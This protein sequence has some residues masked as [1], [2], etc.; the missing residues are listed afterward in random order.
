MVLRQF[1]CISKYMQTQNLSGSFAVFK[2]KPYLCTCMRNFKAIIICAAALALAGC[3][4]SKWA[5]ESRWFGGDRVVNEGYADVFYFVSTNVLEEKDDNGKDT[6]IAKLTDEEKNALNGEMGFIRNMFGDSLNFF[7]PYYSQ[8]TMNALSLPEKDYHK[9]RSVALKD[10]ESAFRYYLRHKNNG[11][12]YILIGFSQGAMHLVDILKNVSKKDYERM[13]T[14]YSMGYRLSAD[15]LKHR[16]VKA[17]EGADDRGTIVSF[18]SVAT[19]DAIWPAVNEG[20]VTCMN[21]VNFKTNEEPARFIFNADTLS[22]RVDSKHNV[23]LVNSPNISTYRF[24]ILDAYCKPGNLHHWDI[25]FY[26]DFIRQNAVG[27]IEK[28]KN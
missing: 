1:C 19:A 26:N 12:P 16:Y 21:P 22:V 2:K 3:G 4:A 6:Y 5:D 25:L 10:A 27:K 9:V 24:P 20:A 28:L 13:V 15:D 8:F 17:A 11:R 14:A 23:L 18:N 7:S